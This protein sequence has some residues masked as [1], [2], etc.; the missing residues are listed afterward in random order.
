MLYR[1]T[2]EM[3]KLEKMAFWFYFKPIY[4]FWQFH[5]QLFSR[6]SAH[7]QTLFFVLPLGPKAFAFSDS[8]SLSIKRHKLQVYVA[9]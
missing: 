7:R 5:H 8:I 1:Q 4:S 2:Y 6:V 9:E 3:R